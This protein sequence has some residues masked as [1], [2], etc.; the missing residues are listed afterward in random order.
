MTSDVRIAAGS[1]GNAGPAVPG[2]PVADPADWRGNELDQ[3]SGWRLQFDAQEIADLQETSRTIR[4]RIGNDPNGLIG[5]PQE[6]FPLGAFAPKL[7]TIMATLTSGAGI[8]L[9]R[10]LP[11]DDM[12][13]IDA[14]I[15]YWGI[16]RHMGEA[17][18]NNPDGDLLGHVT[19]LGKDY[20]DPNTRGYQTNV[21]MDYHCDQ[22]SLV[23]LLCVE[24]AKAGGTSIVASSVAVYNAMLEQR[25]DLVAELMQPLC[26]TKHGEADPGADPFYRSPVFNFL[27][28]RLCTSLG[29]M[30]IFKGHD[31]PGAPDLTEIQREAIDFAATL[32][33][34]IRYEMVL[35]K[36]DIQFANN[37]TIVHTRTEYEDWPGRK[38]LLWRLW[39]INDAIRPPTDY[40]LQWRNGAALKQTEGRIVL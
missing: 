7:Q 38:R 18:A 5:L 30:H 33:A 31:L 36:G 22:S 19:D 2:Q 14:A 21:T 24:T 32:A 35:E 3:Q 23:G 28:G 4:R 20:N 16:G 11:L 25:P 37:F 8:V 6:M 13:P 29:P 15:I 17:V 10:G 9:L 34:E 1:S 40:T 26:W 39:L 12:D 27:G